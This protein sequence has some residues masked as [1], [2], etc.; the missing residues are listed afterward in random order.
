[1]LEHRRR[2]G[3]ISRPTI[4]TPGWISH[5]L[6]RSPLRRATQTSYGSGTTMVL[7]I[8]P[9]TAQV[10]FR[11]GH[12]RVRVQ[13]THALGWLLIRTTPTSYTPVFLDSER[14]IFIAR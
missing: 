9:S 1:M 3:P 13:L 6:A 2:R 5:L 8:N 12:A 7:Y 14:T 4:P 10:L 11:N